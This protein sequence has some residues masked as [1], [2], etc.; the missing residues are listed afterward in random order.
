MLGKP[1]QLHFCFGLSKPLSELLAAEE[2]RTEEVLTAGLMQGPCVAVA[3]AGTPPLEAAPMT[4]QVAAHAAAPAA[5]PPAAAGPSAGSSRLLPQLVAGSAQVDASWAGQGSP[6]SAAGVA[7]VQPQQQQEQ[8]QQQL[9]QAGVQDTGTVVVQQEPYWKAQHQQQQ[10][11]Q[12]AAPTSLGGQQQ[13]QQQQL[14]LRPTHTLHQKRSAEI[15]E[16][17]QCIVCGGDMG[18][19]SPLTD[20]CSYCVGFACNDPPTQAGKYMLCMVQKPQ[21]FPA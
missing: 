15:P 20:V 21:D 9:V 16:P 10:H 7:A 19:G 17:L 1:E 12:L 14:E 2:Q 6:P 18:V 13:Q 3:A 4:A 5:S 11:E 8:Q